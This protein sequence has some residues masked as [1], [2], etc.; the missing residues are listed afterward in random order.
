MLLAEVL[1]KPITE[2]EH[3]RESETPNTSELLKRIGLA[4]RSNT[5]SSSIPSQSQK[6]SSE[7]EFIDIKPQSRSSPT[8]YRAP[9]QSLAENIYAHQL[10]PDAPPHI[11]AAA[12]AAEKRAKT[13]KNK[14]QKDNRD[15]FVKDVTGKLSKYKSGEGIPKKKQTRKKIKK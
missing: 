10:N 14:K 8:E 4:P 6:Q 12:R 2:V 11:H 3:K 15:Q 9:H 7:N 5:S 1:H 13:A